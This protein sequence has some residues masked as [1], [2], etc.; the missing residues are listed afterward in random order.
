MAMIS[1]PTC[2]TYKNR[3]RRGVVECNHCYG[4]GCSKCN[5]TGTAQ[6]Q[7]GQGRGEI[8]SRDAENRP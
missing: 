8:D 7:N 4:R 1:C 2:T 5:N 3:Y 6:Y